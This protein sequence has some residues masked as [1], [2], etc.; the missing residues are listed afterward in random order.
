MPEIVQYF[1]T[2]EFQPPTTTYIVPTGDTPL[3]EGRSTNNAHRSAS[4][5]PR[6]DHHDGQHQSH[7]DRAHQPG[8]FQSV[9]IVSWNV[10]RTKAK[11]R[12]EQALGAPAGAPTVQH[13]EREHQPAPPP[14][15][16]AWD[17][18]R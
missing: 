16:P 15:E 4:S 13:G 8:K 7:H 1:V 14:M 11:A 18:Q 5:S 9:P 17:A 6:P 3:H 12:K 2:G 10:E